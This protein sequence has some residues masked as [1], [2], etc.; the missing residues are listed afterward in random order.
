MDCE[1]VGETKQGGFG[2]G[3]C[4]L[5]CGGMDGRV[6]GDEEDVAGLASG[7]AGEGRAGATVGAVEVDVDG[8]LPVGGGEFGEGGIAGDAGA[9]DEEVGGVA[10]EEIAD[11]VGLGDVEFAA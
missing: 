5:A 1:V 3:I 8:V 10:G 11:D 9:A 4:S 7:H 6:T 2:G